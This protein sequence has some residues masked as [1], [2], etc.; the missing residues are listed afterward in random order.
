MKN[1]DSF[2]LAPT[3]YL[4]FRPR[5][6][7]ALFEYLAGLCERRERA[8][9]AATGNGQ[10]AV[11]LAE[12]FEKVEAFDSSAEQIAAAIDHP[13]VRYRVGA[14]ERLPYEP[15]SIDLVAVAQGAHW[16]DLPAFY[17]ELER[18]A[19]RRA[20]VAIWGYSYCEIT[21]GIDALVAREL[22]EPIEPYWA[23]GN[24]VILDRYRSIP[25]PY[26]EISPPPFVMRHDWTRNTFFGY[27]GTWSAYKRYRLEHERD[28]L[29]RLGTLLDPLWAEDEPKPVAFEL[30]MRV[31][32]VS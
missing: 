10:A 4:R 28:P 15:D 24:R 30:V 25:F 32:R 20:V 2:G 27:L 29:A 21:P 11:G 7:R 26:E 1:K 9:D 22:L 13:K 23:E 14:A 3:E 31:G 19:R 18:V 12:F 5:Y 16:F 8:L 6:P 17:S